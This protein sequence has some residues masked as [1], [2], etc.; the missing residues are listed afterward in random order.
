MLKQVVH[1]TTT[2][3]K[4][5]I[6][7]VYM[8]LAQRWKH[9]CK[10][11]IN[12]SPGSVQV[13]STEG[14]L[15]KATKLRVPQKSWL[16]CWL[17]NILCWSSDLFLLPFI[18]I[19]GRLESILTMVYVVQNY[20]TYFGLYPSSGMRKTKDH[21]VSETGSGSV[22]RWMGQHKPTMSFIV[23]LFLPPTDGTGC[24]VFISCFLRTGVCP[25]IAN[26]S[27]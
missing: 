19:P 17:N 8:F 24:R 6:S 1:R 2:V 27:F 26:S 10:K 5:L 21:N 18:N 3:F 7:H 9:M 16:Q 23:I 4:G 25:V 20:W 22:L 15:K 14:T 13:Q 11:R 12:K